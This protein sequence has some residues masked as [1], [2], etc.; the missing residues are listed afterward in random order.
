MIT[1]GKGVA[2]AFSGT[3]PVVLDGDRGGFTG[4][5]KFKTGVEDGLELLEVDRIWLI[6]REAE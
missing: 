4:T 3:K 5:D 2:E 1:N 6:I